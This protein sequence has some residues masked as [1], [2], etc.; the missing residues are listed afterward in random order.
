LASGYSLA[1]LEENLQLFDG[2]YRDYSMANNWRIQLPRLFV[3]NMLGKSEKPFVYFG[4]TP[5]NEEMEIEILQ[6]SEDAE[7]SEFFNFLRLYAAIFFNDFE[8]AEKCL[9]KLSDD[10][11]GIWIPW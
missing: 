11:E 2:L 8:L 4:S 10:I 6:D 5:E 7:A 3:S 9:A 1:K